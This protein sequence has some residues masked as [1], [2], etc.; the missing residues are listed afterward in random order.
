MPPRPRPQPPEPGK[1]F[2]PAGVPACAV[3]PV[4]PHMP[5][6]HN[7]LCDPYERINFF[8]HAVPGLVLFA[9]LVARV[10]GAVPGGW[11]L[12]LHLAVTTYAHFASALT[13]LSP[14]SLAPQKADHMGI[15]LWIL[16]TTYT[17]LGSACPKM[18][19]APYYAMAAATVGASFVRFSKVRAACMLASG[20]AQALWYF[21]GL[22]ND[23]F[24]AE[25][26]LY[27]LGA[28]LYI[29]GENFGD[30]R[31]GYSD[32]HLMHYCVTVAAFL[33]VAY[34]LKSEG[35]LDAL[36]GPLSVFRAGA[37]LCH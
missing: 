1:D 28:A 25:L 21:H 16:S 18:G 29:R 3:D 6:W 5:Y 33:H 27:A 31:W 36:P 11:P 13:H 34:I 23:L 8:S 22:M 10:A 24:A 19:L 17:S 30:R 12:T 26:A 2:R 7:I 37:P 35:H 9:L 4:F 14:D 32:H 20:T 15:A